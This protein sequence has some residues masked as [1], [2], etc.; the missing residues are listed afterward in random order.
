MTAGGESPQNNKEVN[1]MEN[2]I[3]GEQIKSIDSE[4][5]RI[6][7][8]LNLDSEFYQPLIIGALTLNFNSIIF[9]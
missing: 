6:K 1:K 8:V 2:N 9:Y 4:I 7:I 3:V 5:I